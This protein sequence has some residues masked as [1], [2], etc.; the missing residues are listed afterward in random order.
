MTVIN[1]NTAAINAQ[2]N[3][4]KVQG[5]MEDA[6][7][8]LSSGKRINSAADDAAGLAISA[9]MESQVRGLQMSIRNANDGIS[10]VQS[11]EGALQE[12]T[13]I[14]QRMYE[15]T[16]Q[17][18]NTT[19]NDSDRAALQNEIGQ[20]QS[21]L[22]RIAEDTEFNGQKMLDGSFT[23]KTLSVG[24][25][26]E[27]NI[28]FSVAD[29]SATGLSAEGTTDAVMNLMSTAANV[30]VGVANQF[31]SSETMQSAVTKSAAES[32]SRT[33]DQINVGQ[34][35]T[36]Q[37]TRETTVANLA[38]GAVNSTAV[39]ASTTTSNS[40]A[41]T[42]TANV[43]TYV[44]EGSA[45]GKDEALQ[46]LSYKIN[47][48]IEAGD[49]F[50]IDLGATAAT[51]VTYT[52]KTGDLG[53]DTT[54]TKRNAI[55]SF[56]AQYNSQSISERHDA[57]AGV[58]TASRS[59]DDYV[60]FTAEVGSGTAITETAAL[61][62]TDRDDTSLEA[63]ATTTATAG[64]VS[65]GTA[66]GQ[67]TGD[68][69]I[70][71]TIQAGDTVQITVAGNR[72]LSYV[73]Q[74][75][76]TVTTAAANIVTQFNSQDAAD[77]TDTLG[78]GAAA[79]GAITATSA[80]GVVTFTADDNGVGDFTL[81][82]TVVEKSTDHFIQGNS[83]E[84][85]TA[86]DGTL[87][88]FT[89]LYI[90]GNG[91][92]VG[93]TV[94]LAIDSLTAVTYTVQ[95][96]DIGSLISDT[97]DNIRDSVVAAWNA[98]HASS[99]T[100][101]DAGAVVATA[102]S[103]SN[104]IRLT[105]SDTTSGATFSVST[106]SVANAAANTSTAVVKTTTSTITA[107]TATGP[108]TD[109]VARTQT[110]RLLNI[111][112]NAEAGDVIRFD[113]GGV[114]KEYTVASAE[115]GSGNRGTLQTNL[116]A[117]IN[118]AYTATYVPDGRGEKIT[119]SGAG[120]ITASTS[121][122]GIMLT[123]QNYGAASDFAASATTTNAAAVA[124]VDTV[125]LAGTMEEGDVIKLSLG[126]TNEISFTVTEEISLM[127]AA[128]QLEAVRDGLVA[129][130]H[131]LENVTLS[132]H[133]SDDEKFYVTS[134]IAGTAFTINTSRSG[135]TNREARQQVDTV[136]ISGEIGK[137]DVFAVAFDNLVA[138]GADATLSYAVTQEVAELA[139]NDERIAAVRDALVEK[140]T[141]NTTVD[142][143]VIVAASG[144]GSIELTARL[145]GDTFST[146]FSTTTATNNSTAASQ[147]QI[148]TLSLS[149]DV[150]AGDSFTIDLGDGNSV[151]YTA[152]ATDVSGQSAESRLEAVRD[153]LMAASSALTGVE[154]AASGNAAL[155][156]TAEQAGVGF[157]AQVSATNAADVAQIEA[158]SFANV[159]A[160]DSF[161]VSIGDE[162]FTYT[163][164]AGEGSSEVAAWMAANANFSGKSL[165]VTDGSLMIEGAGGESFTVAT[166]TSNFAGDIQ[167]DSISLSGTV[168]TNDSY[169]VSI[170]GTDV[171]YAVAADDA[172]MGDVAANLAA[173]I[174]GSD[175][176]S[177]VTAS[178]AD[179]GTL[180]L[181]AT[182][183]GE[184]YNVSVSVSDTG[185]SRNSVGA[186]DIST[187][188]GANA[189]KEVLL[190]AI[191]QVNET[192]SELGAIENRLDHTI[193]NLGNVVVNTEAS[194]SQILDADF[195]A[196]TSAL[197]KS[198]ILSQAATAML[199]QANASKQSILSLLQG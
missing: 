153:G 128:D 109:G 84:A 8:R 72:T 108:L 114:E 62:I 120:E 18:S 67:A 4:N 29:H 51:A 129:Q 56:V 52:V 121:G 158:V 91:W 85:V 30:A 116:V 46:V 10:L 143:A 184:G 141:T 3:L 179:D 1:T 90:D 159:E 198:Q 136:T 151:S 50:T 31:G 44:A 144:N 47:G 38:V 42:D 26:A 105:A 195:A 157:T 36:Q 173:A 60:V 101:T 112:T 166:S 194:K 71:G 135:E 155:T 45:T 28:N 69:T 111:G 53:A 164:G 64:V 152:T 6:M 132:N 12:S 185:R 21:E 127:A 19:Y 160:G 37:L 41:G 86:A 77:K 63:T 22:D 25:G 33:V 142:D 118:D 48:E 180:T 183:R 59:G 176:A 7:E 177:A 169:T 119:L 68:V 97:R 161:T 9:R 98:A 172:T 82:A 32:I 199:A 175:A 130:S 40:A 92:E 103:D 16:V 170:D 117:F 133:A 147:K 73:V 138:A 167:S 186:I 150:E 96:S 131:L 149:G 20:L 54:E 11:V 80:L 49:Q 146:D 181:T 43:M 34:D 140:L 187:E 134:D 113:I 55:D 5:S 106:N 123:S 139:T 65:D 197:T 61:S 122:N 188:A 189:A 110:T 154:V 81:A 104:G 191:G 178:A 83:T 148:E 192:R 145:A 182:E 196:E 89:D 76:D 193:S 99:T 79:V 137:G 57:A 94:S 87:A 93:D 174:N 126:S 39:S 75:G 27:G 95:N 156:L 124:Q 24:F 35:N 88:A 168:E 102:G 70:A 66:A 78:D 115:A 13:N 2:Y 15:L 100:S 23:D 162:S 74:T 163:A 58:L 17:A 165:S 125:T 107:G 14:L 190:G 171:T